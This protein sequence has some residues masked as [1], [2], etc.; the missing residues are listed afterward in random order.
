MTDY[1]KSIYVSN[2][3]TTNEGLHNLMTNSEFNDYICIVGE[4]SV[5]HNFSTKHH[6]L[7]VGNIY[8]VVPVN[9]LDKTRINC[10]GNKCLKLITSIP[11]RKVKEWD[12]D[13]YPKAYNDL[14]EDAKTRSGGER[15]KR[16]HIQKRTKKS[17]SKKSQ[18]KRSR[19][20]RKGRKTR[21]H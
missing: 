11:D 9:K 6:G 15:P 8:R 1:N 17:M 19:A 20:N 12:K 4:R 13:V 18:K 21:R 2:V 3:D 7:P 10:Q 5:F 16:N 14:M